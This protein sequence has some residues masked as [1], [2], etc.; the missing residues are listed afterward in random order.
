LFL[1]PL[2]V[3]DNLKP[4]K[5]KRTFLFVLLMICALSI[6]DELKGKV[7]SKSTP[8]NLAV[9]GQKE[10][11]LS[12]EEIKRFIRRVEEIHNIDKSNL[13]FKERRKLRKELMEIKES[14]RKDGGYIYIGTGTIVIIIILVML[15]V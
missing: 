14:V 11:K 5:M 3:L 12:E 2:I 13:T 15:L 4:Q 7:D 10:N 1:E 6:S 9:P 8:D